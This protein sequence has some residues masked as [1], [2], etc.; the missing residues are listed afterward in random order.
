[1]KSIE[2]IH[3]GIRSSLQDEGRVGHAFHAVPRSGVMDYVAY[4][5]ISSI[6]Q[7]SENHTVIECTLKAP[8]ICFNDPM[9]IAIS[10]ADMLWKLNELPIERDRQIT[11]KKGDV[12]AG[13][14]AKTGFRG[15]IGFCSEMIVKKHFGSSSSYSYA[16]LGAN[17]G[18]ALK[19]GDKLFFKNSASKIK[20]E[21]SYTPII[22][23]NKIT[24]Q[25]G[26]EYHLLSSDAI[27]KIIR[28]TFAVSSESNRM[29]A[30]LT[31]PKIEGYQ[32][33]MESVAVLPGFVQ[34][35]PSGQLVVILQDG[36]TTGG[37][38]RIAS[39]TQPE[40]SKFNQIAIGKEI[41]VDFR[42]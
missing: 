8:K 25:K 22:Y 13:N 11:V 17:D 35:L 34:L 39:L 37:Y 36:Q 9:I 26:P 31:G 20:T 6:L 32:S 1:M 10:G 19:K 3:P 23:S 41:K 33:L 40:L 16:S 4:D 5:R 18:Q 38:P 30:R 29:G 42:K 24:L 15:Y 12:L 7:L 14:Y 27:D 2:I 28:G 21:I